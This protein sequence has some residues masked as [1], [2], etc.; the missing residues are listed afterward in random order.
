MNQLD[1]N[2]DTKEIFKQKVCIFKIPQ[3]YLIKEYPFVKQPV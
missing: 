3:G 1:Y 2:G